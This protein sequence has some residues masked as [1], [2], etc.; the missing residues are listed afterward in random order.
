MILHNFGKS[1]AAATGAVLAVVA[2]LSAQSV[3]GAGTPATPPSTRPTG[4][5]TVL[6]LDS[7]NKLVPGA[8]IRLLALHGWHRHARLPATQP[9]AGGQ[10]TPGA[11]GPTRE[12][13]RPAPIAQGTSD[14]NGSFTFTDIPSGRYGVMAMMRK[15]GHGH[16][17]VELSP[18]ADGSANAHV[19]ITLTPP[20]H[21]R[22]GGNA[23]ATQPS[24]A[25][26][27]G[28]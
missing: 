1:L 8:M 6:V 9:A 21:H 26:Q 24:N 13:H 28:A 14:Q 4:S 25:P 5:I 17:R 22:Y 2:I 7:N 18:G 12:H 23:P 27:G 3:K 11:S 10:A 19:T 16:V 15:V 20:Q